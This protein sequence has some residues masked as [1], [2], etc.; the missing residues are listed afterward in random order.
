VVDEGIGGNRLLNNSVG[1]GQSALTRFARDV[2]D[3]PGVKDVVVLEGTND[4]Q[5]SQ[6]TTALTNPHTEVSPDQI[7]AG[8]RGAHSPGPRGRPEDLRWDAAPVS[9]VQH[10]SDAAEEATRAAVNHWILSSGAFDGVID[11]AKALA[12][13]TDPLR[14]NPTYDSGDH[15][16]PNDAGYRAMAEA[17]NLVTL[18]VGIDV[19]DGYKV[20]AVGAA[21]IRSE[22]SNATEAR[23]TPAAHPICRLTSSQAAVSVVVSK[24]LT[25]PAAAL[26]IPP[27]ALMASPAARTASAAERMPIRSPRGSDPLCSRRGGD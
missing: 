4:V 1:Y 25:A 2:L 13:P 14:L 15:L 8:Y 16:H 19:T 18:G 9:R 20:A 5:F 3:V 6:L 23:P 7:I 26:W 22:S 17:V 11:F 27:R 21:G 12:D 24:P 10:G